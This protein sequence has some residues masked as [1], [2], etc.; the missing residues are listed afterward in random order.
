[1]TA[2]R[3]VALYTRLWELLRFHLYSFLIC[4]QGCLILNLQE[5][6]LEPVLQD[7]CSLVKVKKEVAGAGRGNVFNRNC[8]NGTKGSSFVLGLKECGFYYAKNLKTS[9]IALNYNTSTKICCTCFYWAQQVCLDFKFLSKAAQWNMAHG[10]H[11][12][13]RPL[14]RH[15]PG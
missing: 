13:S 5:L 11:T 14:P 8:E 2:L 12:S 7:G 4:V 6:I 15:I 1:M 10:D 9:L 3:A